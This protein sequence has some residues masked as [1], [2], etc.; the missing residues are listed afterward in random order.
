[1][2]LG[3]LLIYQDNLESDIEDAVLTMVQ[4]HV[5]EA[6]RCSNGVLTM[7]TLDYNYAVYDAALDAASRDKAMKK[8]DAYKAACDE[9]LGQ[10]NFKRT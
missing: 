2:D 3:D 8:R 10:D 5:E 7:I 9:A 4:E 1:M 6:L